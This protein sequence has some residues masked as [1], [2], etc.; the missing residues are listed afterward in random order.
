M[1]IVNGNLI[2]II[3]GVG[4]VMAFLYSWFRLRKSIIS[5]MDERYITH[6]RFNV[7]KDVLHPKI[8]QAESGAIAQAKDCINKMEERLCQKIREY[9]A[10]KIELAILNEKL[11]AL[12]EDVEEHKEHLKEGK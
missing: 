12:K 4:V 10:T 8:R 7:E 2:Q 5:Q 9:Y 1:E 11:K 3:S 6:H